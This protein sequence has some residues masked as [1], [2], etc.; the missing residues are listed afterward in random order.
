MTKTDAPTYL[1]HTEKEDCPACKAILDLGQRMTDAV[2]AATSLNPGDKMETILRLAA[3]HL[4]SFLPEGMEIAGTVKAAQSLMTHIADVM[5][6]DRL[7]KAVAADIQATEA[8]RHIGFTDTD[9]A[10]VKPANKLPC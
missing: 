2:N 6:N 9:L 5:P 8:K 10:N 3:L 7:R 4:R 1:E